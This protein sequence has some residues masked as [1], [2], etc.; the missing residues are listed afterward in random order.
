MK[1]TAWTDKIRD[2]TTA[3]RCEVCGGKL[4]AFTVMNDKK[5]AA[6]RF[7]TRANA[8]K[9]QSECNGEIIPEQLLHCQA[10]PKMMPLLQ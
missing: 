4:E 10:A 1:T 6:G 3:R 2:V 9:R 7:F 5:E 8:E